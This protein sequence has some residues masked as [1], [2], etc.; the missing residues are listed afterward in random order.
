MGRSSGMSGLLFFLFEDGP[1]VLRR[2]GEEK[3]QARLQI[4]QNSRTQINPFH[5]RMSGR[6]KPNQIETAEG[7]R[8]FI[9][10]ADVPPHGIAC[11]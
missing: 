2:P 3:H 5:S 11:D 6:M 7:R 8:K 10:S 4:F 1:A 9:L